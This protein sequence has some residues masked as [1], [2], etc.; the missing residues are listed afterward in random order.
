[1]PVV[2]S[3]G[4]TPGSVTV[5]R[6]LVPLNDN[7]PPTL[8]STRVAAVMAPLRALGEESIAVVPL[9]SSNVSARTTLAGPDDTTTA[10]LLPGCAKLL[11]SGDWLMMLPRRI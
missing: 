11:A 7:A 1:M 10:T 6:L 8:P 4:E 2:R 9:D 5:T 3:S